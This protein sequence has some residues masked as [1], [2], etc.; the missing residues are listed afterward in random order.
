MLFSL[1]VHAQTAIDQ[2]DFFYDETGAIIETVVS[3][4]EE[5]ETPM[6]KRRNAVS[7]SASESIGGSIDVE[8]KGSNLV[9]IH[10]DKRSV[11]LPCS[12][13]VHSLSGVQMLRQEIGAE[14]CRF[15]LNDLPKG[16]YI[17]SLTING[18]VESKKINV[19]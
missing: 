10:I 17:I 18:L 4:D 15:E 5:T 7:A 2:I 14:M 11:G 12:I 19:R 16:T 9:E 13:S 3:S 8:R 6:S 1:S